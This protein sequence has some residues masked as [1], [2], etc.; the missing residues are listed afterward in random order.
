VPGDAEQPSED[1]GL[2]REGVEL[3]ECR[4][5]HLLH[6]ILDEVGRR[7][8]SLPHVGIDWIGVPRHE[9]GGRLSILL[10][11]GDEQ[12]MLVCR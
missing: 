6:D 4:E 11:H 5:K 9:F 10:E 3:V 7:R 8:E 12:G 2:T 1:A